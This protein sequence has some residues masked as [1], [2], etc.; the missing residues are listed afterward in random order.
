MAKNTHCRIC[1]FFLNGGG[2]GAESN[3]VLKRI[4]FFVVVLHLRPF[5][6]IIHIDN[7]NVFKFS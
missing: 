1:L 6:E 7:K 5:V 4:H 3:A 2:G